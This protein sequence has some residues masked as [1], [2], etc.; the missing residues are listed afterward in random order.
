ME[1]IKKNVHMNRLK[2]HIVTQLTLDD[3]FNVPDVNDDIYRI[4]TKDGYVLQ[5]STKVQDGK[6]TVSG[7]LEFKFLY[8]GS[9]DNGKIH[10]MSGSI[11]FTETI[12]C[13]N[14]FE[15]DGVTVK[16]DIDDLNIG[17]INTRKISTKAI[18]TVS[19]SCEDIYDIETACMPDDENKVLGLKH[20]ADVTQLAICKKDIYRIKENID[21][22]NGKPNI[23]EIIWDTVCLKSIST[24]LQSGKISITGEINLFILYTAQ[25]E[26]VPVQWFDTTFSFSNAIDMPGCDE[27][28]IGDISVNIGS[29]TITLKNDYDGEPRTLEPDIVLDL[30]IKIYKEE[31]VVFLTDAYSP[32]CNVIPTYSQVTYNTIL[33]K[34]LSKC[35]LTD[36]LKLDSAKGQI[37]QLLSSC[38]TPKIDEISVTEDGL[39][40]EG[41][42]TAKLMYI[43]SDDKTPLAIAD[44]II[45]FTHT[46]E[47][48]GVTEDSLSFIRPSMEQMSVVMTGTNEVEVKADV[49]LD[50][51]ILNNNTCN[52]ITDID[53]E[54]FDSAWLASRPGMTG[55]LVKAGDTLWDIA[56]AF[57][58]TKEKIMEMNELK[59]DVVNPGDML[60][61]L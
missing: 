14:V 30:N 39:L 17:I 57:H 40:V 60:L 11:P 59:S 49:L 36:K 4:I 12:N 23:A 61:I 54:D 55:Y 34:N 53:T 9:D 2:S 35:R 7:S 42:V 8:G 28:M 19:V 5:N 16:W 20:T 18:I 50:C 52:V 3:D 13:D 37:L 25:E 56:K 15:H 44:E 27:D 33:T 47:A 41:V 58:S 46:I 21:L 6:V 29:S 26:N 43:S 51:L 38:G 10:H 45:P 24:K 48:K 32:E 31:P 22:P 1:L